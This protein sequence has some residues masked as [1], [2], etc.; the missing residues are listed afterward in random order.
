MLI[1]NAKYHQK[2]K[3]YS[4]ICNLNYFLGIFSSFQRSLMTKNTY[5][6]LQDNENFALKKN[7][8]R[9]KN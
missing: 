8:R 4:I 5:D 1:F 9:L 6:I 3:I 2:Y 7:I